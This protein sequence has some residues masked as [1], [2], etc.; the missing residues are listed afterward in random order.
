MRDCPKCG[1]PVDG[2]SCKECGEG[3]AVTGKGTSGQ[4]WQCGHYD[5]GQRCAGLGVWSPSTT[6]TGPWFCRLHDG[7]AYVGHRTRPPGGFKQLQDVL[8]KESLQDAETYA[9]RRA[10]QEAD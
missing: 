8:R 2:V 3:K 6:G 10:L 1:A 4:D 7:R 9:E 5:R